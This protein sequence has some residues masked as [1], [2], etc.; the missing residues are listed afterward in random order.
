MSRYVCVS[1]LARFYGLSLSRDF[2]FCQSF[3]ILLVVSHVSRSIFS[4]LSPMSAD[5]YFLGCLPCESFTSPCLFGSSHASFTLKNPLQRY[6]FFYLL[7]IYQN[8]C[9][10]CLLCSQKTSSYDLVKLLTTC[11]RS[12]RFT[13]VESGQRMLKNRKT[14]KVLMIYFGNK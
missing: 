1:L 12:A 11:G 14:K 9:K 5:S 3:A 4:W 8:I 10:D 6:S 13:P 7:V 2:Q